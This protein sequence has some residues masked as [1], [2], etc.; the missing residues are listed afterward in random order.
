MELKHVIR[1]MMDTTVRSGFP[2]LRMYPELERGGYG[3]SKVIET[4]EIGFSILDE[5][6]SLSEEVASLWIS[7]SRH[8]KYANFATGLLGALLPSAINILGEVKA[9]QIL[10]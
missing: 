8:N 10:D 4:A 9:P 7:M 6:P 2:F 1:V 5:D 3:I